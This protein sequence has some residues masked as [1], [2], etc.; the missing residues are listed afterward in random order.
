MDEKMRQKHEIAKKMKNA[1]IAAG[2]TQTQIAERLGLTYQA[3][4]N[5]ER[6]KNS[7]DTSLF[8][9]MCALYHIDPVAVFYEN[10]EICPKCGFSYNPNEQAE[11]KMHERF[12]AAAQYYELCYPWGALGLV[13]SEA[14][15]ILYSEET[16]FDEKYD[17][18][19]EL[20]KVYF[21]RS[22]GQHNYQL[23]HPKFDLYASMLLNQ[24]RF[25]ELFGAKVYGALIKKYG[26]RPGIPEGETTYQISELSKQNKEN[27]PVAISSNEVIQEEP[28]KAVQGTALTFRSQGTSFYDALMMQAATETPEILRMETGCLALLDQIVRKARFGDQYDKDTLNCAT[29]LLSI[30]SKGLDQSQKESS[31]FFS[32]ARRLLLQT[33]KLIDTMAEQDQKDPDSARGALKGIGLLVSWTLYAFSV[34]KYEEFDDAWCMCMEAFNKYGIGSEAIRREHEARAEAETYYWQRLS[35]KKQESPASSANE[36][37]AD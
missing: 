14:Y 7:I 12:C 35:E 1:R 5:Y 36:S 20:L 13:K 31:S 24:N 16:S 32:H 10:A 11:V 23:D 33:V 3:I 29:D 19:L 4:S 18:S 27:A 9:K 34:G 30:C 17:A 8:M 22:V 2:L 21:S 26:K 15:D 25:E 28:A 37:G 6:G